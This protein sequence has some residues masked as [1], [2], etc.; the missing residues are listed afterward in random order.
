M[1]GSLGK[2]PTTM[3][4]ESN[5]S[6]IRRIAELTG[7]YC[8]RIVLC[9]MGFSGGWCTNASFRVNGKG[10]A[11]DFGDWWLDPAFDAESE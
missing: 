3:K 11:T 1:P 4:K 7:F 6:I 8:K 10:C 9:E 5:S 2:E